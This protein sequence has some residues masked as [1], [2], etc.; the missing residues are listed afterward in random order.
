VE[1][2]VTGGA[3]SPDE[4]P[5]FYQSLDYVFIPAVTEGG[6]LCFQEG[7]AS[8]KEIV[9]TDVGMVH[10]FIGSDGIHIFD[11]ENPQSLVNLLSD[12]YA[13]KV[14]L[15]SHIESYSISYFVESHLKI[16]HD[17]LMLKK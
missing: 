12:L 7:L 13:K 9:S 17:R 1:L 4:I 10:D 3:L 8:G 11:R 6:P 14:R 16:F 15:R 5:A 2:R